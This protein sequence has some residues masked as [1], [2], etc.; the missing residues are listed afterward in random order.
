MPRKIGA[1]AAA[2]AGCVV[3]MLGAMS[4]VAVPGMVFERMV[5]DYGLTH[6]QV[7]L[8]PSVG[9]LGCM[10]FIGVG[11]MLVD[12][13]GWMRMLL[14]GSAVQAIGY[15]PVHET[16]NLAAMLAGELLN[17]GGRTIVYLSILKLFDASFGR[18]RFAALIGV[19]Y[20]FSYGGTLGASAIFPALM[21]RCGSWQL[22]A[23]A[24]NFGTLAAATCIALLAGFAQKANAAPAF[25]GSGGLFPWKSM[26]AGFRAPRARA[27]MIA[28]ALN[29]AAYW[30]FLCVGAAPFARTVGDVSMVS[31]MNW[32]VM[33]GITLMGGVSLLLGNAR[34]P[35][36]VWGSGALVA[37]FATLLV[38]SLCGVRD[39]SV[40]RTA[41]VLVGAGYG[42]TSVLLAGTKECVPATYMA[43][44]IGFTNF[45]ANV[46]Q[47]ATNQA[48][49]KLMSMGADGHV[50][51]FAT[52]LAISVA[53][54]TASCRFAAM[55]GKPR[56]DEV[57]DSRSRSSNDNMPVKGRNDRNRERKA[58]Q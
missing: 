25:G 56:E 4:R 35:F 21:E 32:V 54:L 51:L 57:S 9:V 36:F 37:A 40:Y 42:V 13:F 34:R 24:I 47:I 48:S 49:G 16:P 12:R 43:S 38:A 18:R 23:R 17:G 29:I 2:F 41:Y 46:V 6:A 10:A 50:P 27:A 53:S 28:T 31:D 11:G 20:V 52:Y 39:V 5:S 33:A 26:A 22:A 45:F 30:S 15:V 7:A 8:L 14:L 1:I 58:A 55:P 44:A 3:Y 19:F